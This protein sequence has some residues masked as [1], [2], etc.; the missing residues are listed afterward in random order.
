MKKRKIPAWALIAAVATVV[1]L[2]ATWQALAARAD[3]KI[4]RSEIDSVRDES[5]RRLGVMEETELPELRAPLA[6]WSHMIRG[7]HHAAGQ[8]DLS[9][10]SYASGTVVALSDPRFPARPGDRPLPRRGC[11]GPRHHRPGA[12]RAGW[13]VPALPG[14]DRR[15]AGRRRLR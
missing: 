14:D 15:G 11:R 12:G 1:T 13:C 7:L 10:F 4:L 2:L 6:T 8:A 5:D 9:Q 3:N